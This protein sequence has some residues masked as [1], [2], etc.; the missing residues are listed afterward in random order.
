MAR[1][2]LFAGEA[3]GDLHGSALIRSLYRQDD[4]AACMG[5]G[6]PRMRQEQFEC[7][8]ET[9]QFQVMGFFDVIKALPHLW[10]FFYQ[11]RDRIVKEQPDAVIL[12]DYPGFNLRLMKAL[13]KHGYQ[14]KIVQYI[15]PSVWAHGKNRIQILEDCVD[16][17]FCIYPFELASFIDRSIQV[18]Y[19][20]NPLQETIKNYEYR[21][22][23]TKI[24]GLP[25]NQHLVALF[26]GSRMQELR[27]HM[28]LQLLVVEELKKKYPWLIF[29]ICCAQ[30]GLKDSIES[31][32]QKTPLR[33]NRDLFIISSEFSYELM[34]ECLFALA[35]SGT[36]TL[37]LALH[38]VP[39]VVYYE[40]SFLNHL[41]AKYLLRLNLPYYCIVNILGGKGI[42]PELIGK[43]ISSQQVVKESELLYRNFD[44]IQQIKLECRRIKTLLEDGLGNDRAAEMI[45][46]ICQS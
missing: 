26:P 43:N 32:I 19:I 2:F 8:L 46:K 29:V 3:S 12:I 5:V 25:S 33:L 4:S 15:C 30:M 22:N 40:L 35:K 31:L 20:G 41:I 38:E 1:Y 18:E 39:T 21:S 23:W 28:P 11:V 9:E 17:L 13:R 10:R 7:F 27:L 44:R 24:V 34:K 16:L 6:G 36:V 42:F 37:E 14:G 45:R